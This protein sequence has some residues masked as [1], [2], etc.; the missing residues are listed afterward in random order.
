MQSCTSKTCQWLQTTA[1]VLVASMFIYAGYVVNSHMETW[2]TAV[3]TGADDLHSIRQNMNTIA[4][5]MESINQDMDIMKQSVYQGV[6]I[7]DGMKTEVSN[8]T[9][10]VDAMNKQLQYMN[11]S[12][13][14]IN[15]N[16]SP[17]G[18]FGSMMPF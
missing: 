6:V 14:S 18:M 10:T 5:S 12:V 7:A 4:Y 2:S 15:N 16:F 11:Y 8:L 1:Q 17:A 13:G 9:S 3:A